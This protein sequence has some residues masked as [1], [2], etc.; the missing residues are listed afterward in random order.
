ML[1]AAKHSGPSF[2]SPQNVSASLFSSS[3]MRIEI[4]ILNSKKKLALIEVEIYFKIIQN[5]Y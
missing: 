1:E 4:I 2:C 5:L 3:T